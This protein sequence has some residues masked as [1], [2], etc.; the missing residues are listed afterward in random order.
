[1]SAETQK[2]DVLAV[3]RHSVSAL[4]GAA[5]KGA[6]PRRYADSLHEAK[7]AVACLIEAASLRVEWINGTWYVLI[8]G[9]TALTNVGHASEAS[10]RRE[11]D[12]ALR[13]ALAR[14]GGGG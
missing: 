1:M 4:H 2:V 10:A 8:G 9:G 5:D 3:M 7:E 13:A 12:E 14:V 11:A 6:V